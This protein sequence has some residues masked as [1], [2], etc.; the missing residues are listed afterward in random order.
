ME[1]YLDNAATTKPRKEVIDMMNK[2]LVQYYANP[3][4]LHKKGVEVEKLIKTARKQIAKALGSD[5]KEIYFTSGGTESN[6]LAI[7]GSLEGNKRK[8][9]HI[10]TTKIE[11]LSVLNVFKYL[12]EKGYDVTYLSVDGDG[13]IDIEQFK[14]SI[15]DDTAFISI[16]YVNNEVGTIQPIEEIS[17]ILKSMTNRPIFHVD[18]IQAFGKIKFN[19]KKLNVDLMSISGHKIHGPKGIG[20]LYIKKGTKIKSII[21]GG[22]QELGIRSGTENV[23][24]IF[25]LGTASDLFKREFE[26]NIKKM[27]KL[28][29]KLLEGIKR[30]V[31][32]IKINGTI[33]ENSAPHILN[34]SFKGIRGEVLLHSLEQDKIYVSTGSACSS[35]KKTYSHVLREMGLCEKE[36]EGA[37]RFSFSPFNTEEEI[38][39][40]IDRVTYRVAE[41]RKVIAGR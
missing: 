32:D 10:I 17:S 11:H 33:G 29:F 7:L 22:N 25:G 14:N 6:N 9:R 30:N 38:D 23:P 24:G 16:M 36:M 37:I 15:N 8:G 34:M 19:L 20:A 1:V 41:L 28:K 35:R 3:S 27:A 5:E 39:Y 12:E 40:V 31:K 18:A 2:A 13:K 21:F 4:S 26:E